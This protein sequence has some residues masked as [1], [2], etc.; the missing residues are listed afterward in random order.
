VQQIDDGAADLAGA[1]DQDFAFHV[2][3]SDMCRGAR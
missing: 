3:L 1:E 2:G